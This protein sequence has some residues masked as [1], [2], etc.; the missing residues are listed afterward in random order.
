MA[1]REHRSNGQVSAFLTEALGHAVAAIRSCEP[2][3]K[4]LVAAYACEP[5][6]GSEPGVGW[7]MS[8]AISC[9]NEVWVLTRKNNRERIEQ[10]LLQNPN[11]RLHFIYADLPYWARFW[12]R[13]GRGIHLYYY[14]WQFAAWREARKLLRIVEFDLAHHVTFVNS[15]QFS[16]LGL[17]PLPFVWGPIGIN[18]RLPDS[19]ARR[20]RAGPASR[21]RYLATR[22]LR[23]ADPLFWLCVARAR[24]IIGINAEVGRQPPI[25]LLGRSK[26]ICHTAIGVDDDDS[27]PRA[28]AR[29]NTIRVLSVGRLV[30]IKG[31]DLTLRAF[32]QYSRSDPAATLVVVG[33]GPEKPWLQQLTV[34]LGIEEAV[35]FIPWLPRQAAIAMMDDADVFLYPSFEGAGMVVLEALAHGLPVVCLDFGGP[36]Q[37]VTSDC[38]IVVEVGDLDATV[39]AL[40]NGLATLA[41]DASL[42]SAMGQAA[43]RRAA[44]YLWRTRPE[45]VAKWYSA[46]LSQQP[47]SRINE[48]SA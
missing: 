4:I 42:R 35:K 1:A 40:A 26:F 8:Q 16:F 34:R 45:A 19:L 30:P 38:G 7:N 20:V 5:N 32:A 48:G 6:A 3:R 44:Q 2:R 21:L 29:T 37:M 25:S 9:D 17:L 39:S 46:A 24:L 33:D 15:Y 23:I 12:K 43:S 11:P 10:A 36:G 18:P 28:R 27:P 41:R 47:A 31:L 13:G 22:L 14:L